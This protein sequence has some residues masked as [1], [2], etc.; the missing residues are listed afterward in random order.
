MMF[1]I[2]A[3][4]IAALLLLTACA[5]IPP[6]SLSIASIQQFRIVDVVIEG[7]DVIRSWPSEEKAVI[8]T[9][10]IDA[11]TANRLQSQSASQFP[12]L[13]AHFQK[14]LTARLKDEFATH[15]S[16]IL[17]GA[18]PVKA[19][20][21]LRVFDIPSAARRVLVDQ[22][23]KI[24]ADIDLVD[25]AT[26]AILLHYQGPYRMQQ[27]VGGVATVVALAF[28]PADP[29]IGMTKEYVAAYAAWLLRN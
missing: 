15:V 8:E 27:L 14:V 19:V 29:S 12:V 6:P 5:T 21:R 2:R 4:A 10:A 23:I 16:P 9:G 24:Q 22:D 11:E 26:R 7:V 18:R 17:I 25:P 3:A 20:V 13:R 1:A 28:E